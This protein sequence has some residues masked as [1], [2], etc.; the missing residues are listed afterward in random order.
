MQILPVA[1]WKDKKGI[2]ITKAFPKILDKS[3]RK[4][5]KIWVNKGSEFYSR[6]RNSWLQYNDIEMYST[7]N[8]EKSVVAERFITTLKK[9]IYKYRTP[10]SKNLY[11]DK[12]DDVVNRCNNTYKRV[13]KFEV[14]DHLRILKI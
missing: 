8:E 13:S 11:I 5:S 10:V 4:P 12:L 2:T 7:H 9:I 1:P 14:G 3:N 6:S